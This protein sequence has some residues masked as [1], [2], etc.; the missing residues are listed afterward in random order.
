MNAEELMEEMR[1]DVDRCVQRNE[2]LARMRV[3]EVDRELLQRL[4]IAEHNCQESELAAY[5][6]LVARHR[7]ETPARLF[8][9]TIHTIAEAHALMGP[10]AESVGL[11]P[12][13]LK[14]ATSGLLGRAVGSLTAPGALASPAAVALYLHS[15]LAVWCTVFDELA[16][17]AGEKEAAP[18]P[19]IDYLEW[20]GSEPPATLTSGVREVITYGLAHGEEPEEVLTFARQ[21]HSIVDDYWGYVSSGR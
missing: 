4:V 3:G 7:H 18:E 21:L 20:W 15:D 11:R 17:L 14:I 12:E 6:L 19:L 5:G 2:T 9:F 13:D 16:R 1:P 8:G 10:V